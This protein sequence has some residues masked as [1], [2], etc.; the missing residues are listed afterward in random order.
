MKVMFLSP[1]YTQKKGT[2]L[3]VHGKVVTFAMVC[4]IV[5]LGVVS[6]YYLG[7]NWLLWPIEGLMIVVSPEYIFIMTRI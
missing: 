2:Y 5:L 7:Y 3:V 1:I 6:S 4:T